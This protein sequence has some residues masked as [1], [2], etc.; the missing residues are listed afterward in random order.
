MSRK[1]KKKS[2]RPWKSQEINLETSS[3]QDFTL[4]EDKK[5]LKEALETLGRQSK[6]A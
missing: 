4:I 6:K 2:Q 1:K 5:L 3:H